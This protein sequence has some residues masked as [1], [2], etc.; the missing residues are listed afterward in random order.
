MSYEKHHSPTNVAIPELTTQN[1][2]IKVIRQVVGI[3]SNKLQPIIRAHNDIN[4]R[5]KYISIKPLNYHDIFQSKLS[6]GR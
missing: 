1:V 5:V 3:D 6:P 2:K 4:Y